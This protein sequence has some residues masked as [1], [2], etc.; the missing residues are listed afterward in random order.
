MEQFSIETTLRESPR[1]PKHQRSRI[2]NLERSPSAPFGVGCR[3]SAASPHEFPYKLPPNAITLQCKVICGLLNVKFSSENKLPSC[4]ALSTRPTRSGP[5]KK[6]LLKHAKTSSGRTSFRDFGPTVCP[7]HK[8]CEPNME[9]F[10]ATA[11]FLLMAKWFK[12]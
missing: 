10:F 4:L 11:K 8:I 9:E 1:M 7:N 6:E 12:R 3:R 5:L 2:D